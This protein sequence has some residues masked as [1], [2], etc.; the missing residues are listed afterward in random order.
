M[1]VA[2]V[3]PAHRVLS[4][5]MPCTAECAVCNVPYPCVWRDMRSHRYRAPFT[6]QVLGD[7]FGPM[8]PNLVEA[9]VGRSVVY[10]AG[11]ELQAQ[12]CAPFDNSHTQVRCRI[13]GGVGRGFKWTIT[14]AGVTSPQL[15]MATSFAPP[16]V[17]L[18]S[19]ELGPR[20]TSAE[21]RVPTQGGATVTLQ[22]TNFGADAGQVRYR[23]PQFRN[24]PQLTDCFSRR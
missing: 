24:A 16:T 6:P 19:V 4:C 8:Q 14:V 3:N 1:A 7:Y 17:S 22:G 15:P 5:W 12:D 20:L 13:P 23:P 10:P 11:G 9:V 18:A 21:P 2:C